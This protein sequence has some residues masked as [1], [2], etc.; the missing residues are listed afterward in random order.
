MIMF[1]VLIFLEWILHDG[2][3]NDIFVSQ[4]L[5][6]QMLMTVLLIRLVKA[7][8]FYRKLHPVGISHFIMSHFP[9]PM[10]RL[11][12]KSHVFSTLTKERKEY[13]DLCSLW[14]KQSMCQRRVIVGLKSSRKFLLFCFY[15]YLTLLTVVSCYEEHS[16]HPSILSKLT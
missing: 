12:N 8:N 14:W 2:A 3:C 7:R 10:V 11:N 1:V 15:T 13:W 4:F 16:R 5:N 9:C 6:S